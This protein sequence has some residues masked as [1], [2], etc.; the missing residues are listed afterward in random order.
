MDNTYDKVVKLTAEI[1]KKS[2]EPEPGKVTP[3]SSSSSMHTEQSDNHLEHYV[4]ADP[5]SEL[6]G[7]IASIFNSNFWTNGGEKMENKTLDVDS[8]TTP[9]EQYN[10]P[11]AATAEPDPQSNIAIDRKSTRLNCSHTD[12]SRMPSSA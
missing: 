1:L 5:K 12:V 9:K 3:F 10:N 4:Q 7:S 6:H 2:W 8:S 11:G